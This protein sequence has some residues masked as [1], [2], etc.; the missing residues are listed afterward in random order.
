VEQ[1]RKLYEFVETDNG[2]GIDHTRRTLE[3]RA[4]DIGLTREQ[5]RATVHAALELG[6]LLEQPLPKD[7]QRGRR[8]NYLARGLR[9]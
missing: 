7:K 4:K 5:L 2:R 9:P 8:Q 6:H 3:D 1:L